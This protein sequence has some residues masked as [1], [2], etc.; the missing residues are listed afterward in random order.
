MGRHC[1]EVDTEVLIDLLEKGLT[2]KE[3]GEELGMSAQ[4]VS[5][6]IARLQNEQGLLVQYRA[7]QSLQLTRLQA[8]V[9]EAITP[10]KIAEASLRDLVT[11]FKI[12]KDKELVIEGKPSDIKGLISYLVHLEKEEVGLKTS[13][14]AHQPL[15]GDEEDEDEEDILDA[16]YIPRL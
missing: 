5:K 6:V 12:L 7:V 15:P 8:Q 14:S 10:S 9:L 13:V 3:M 16:D 4:T 11:A 2:Q 1:K